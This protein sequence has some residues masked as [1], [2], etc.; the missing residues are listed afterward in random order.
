[1]PRPPLPYRWILGLLTAVLVVLLGGGGPPPQPPPA[2][3]VLPIDLS[4]QIQTDRDR[5]YVVGQPEPFGTV[6]RTYVIQAY[7]LPEL[8]PL[9]S[10]QVTVTGDVYTV[11][12]IGDDVLLVGYN[13]TQSAVPGLM[14]VRS[15][16]A[17]PIWKRQA[18]IYGL[19]AD[20]SQLLVQEETVPGRAEGH[21]VWRALDPRTGVVRWSVEQPAGGQVTMSSGYSWSGYPARFFTVDGDGLVAAHDGLTGTVVT[22]TRLPRPP[23]EDFV[24]WSIGGLL[25][26]AYGED[27]TIAYDD[28]TLTERWRRD[29]VV[30]PE[31]GYPADC[32]PMICLIGFINGL[33]IVDPATG[34]GRW[35]TD[36][37][38]AT[39]VIGDRVLVAH[40]SQT[41]PALA[42]V[43]P[44]TGGIV[45]VDGQWSSGGRGPEPGTAWV[46]R[47]QAVGYA[48]RYGILRLSDGKVRILGQA[49][50]I[51]GDCQFTA[52]AMVCRRL[53][54]SIAVWRL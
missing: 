32:G 24:A 53:D 15:G 6:V 38:D 33:S 7:Q 11:A 28:Q 41:D 51:A 3:V 52:A 43:D 46:Y 16:A 10:Y 12:G 4:D 26:A 5:L 49:E 34:Q 23:G 20:R 25:V 17:E 14:A 8:T 35:H 30:L 40:T 37:Y 29:D 21:S 1:M 45:E 54:S 44:R 18:S 22:S 27:E 31:G 36:G 19:T 42:V 48:L 9:A 2:P 39:E 47:H 50:R 13:D